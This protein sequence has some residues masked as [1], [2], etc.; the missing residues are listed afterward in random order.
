M[1]TIKRIS[2][3]AF[4]IG[5]FLTWGVIGAA[6]MGEYHPVR[7]LGWAVFTALCGLI[8]VISHDAD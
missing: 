4:A 1:K 3:A 6:D 2:G 8:W 7:I 5:L